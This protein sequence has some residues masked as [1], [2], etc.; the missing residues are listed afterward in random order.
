MKPIMDI[1]KTL[2]QKQQGRFMTGRNRGDNDLFADATRR[3]PLS[4]N[5]KR[6]F[7]VHSLE[8]YWLTNTI[9]TEG[10]LR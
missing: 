6:T 1:E 8:A 4:V 5:V 10:T 2:V 7:C 3:E 9:K